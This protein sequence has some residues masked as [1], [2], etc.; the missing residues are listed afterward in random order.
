VLSLAIAFAGCGGSSSSGDG[1]RVANASYLAAV[2]RAAYTTDQV[3]GYKFEIDVT[4]KLSGKSVSFGGSGA[5]SE[6]GS[7]GSLS[8]EVDGKPLTELIDKPY[9]YIKSPSDSE[10]SVTHG[11]PWIRANIDVFSESFGG[12]SFSSSSA[13]P[14]Q[15]LSFLKSAG[16]VTRIGSGSVRGAPATHY[17][18]VIDLARYASAAA[19]SERAAAKRYTESFKR[20]SGSSTLPMDVWI[21]GEGR[22]SRMTFTLSICGPGGSRLHESLS[23]ELY[24]YGSQQ[25]VVQTPPS[26]EVTDITSRL[27]TEVAKGLEQLSCH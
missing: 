14:T 20:I 22:V 15:T 10:T 12:G 9:I 13:D 5:I 25:P 17:H 27:K 16:T 8:M 26:S 11:K 2:T 1:S 24:D 21:D 7:Q 4:A 19:P 18:A 23:M 3:P 6:K